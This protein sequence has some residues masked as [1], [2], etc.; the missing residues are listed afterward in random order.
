MHQT[1]T[2]AAPATPSTCA[3]NVKGNALAP[4][5]ISFDFLSFHFDS[6]SKPIL[7][8]LKSRTGEQTQCRIELPSCQLRERV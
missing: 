4:I 7:R 1:R 6:P 5:A 3:T 2:I 8:V